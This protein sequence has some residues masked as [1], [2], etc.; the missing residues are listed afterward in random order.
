MPGLR[1][2]VHGAIAEERAEVLFAGMQGGRAPTAGAKTEHDAGARKPGDVARIRGPAEGDDGRGLQAVPNV[3]LPGEIPRVGA[4]NLRLFD[5]NRGAARVR[6]FGNV[7][8]IYTGEGCET[9]KRKLIDRAAALAGIAAW[10]WQEL[11]LP[12]HFKQVIE[13]C[14]TVEERRRGR[15]TGYNAEKK[16]WQRTD[17][18]AIFLICSECRKT[19]LNNGSPLWNFCPYCGA[20]MENSGKEPA[21]GETR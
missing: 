9:M 2:A 10:D 14:P 6:R 20:E 16:E 4:C 13:D 1:E 18:S 19:V 21:E 3:H 15:W 5:H 8:Q 17:G 12:A 7:R 11:Y